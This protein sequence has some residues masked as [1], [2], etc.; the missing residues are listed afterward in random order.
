MPADKS[1][2]ECPFCLVLKAFEDH[3]VGKHIRAAQREVLLAVRT[4]LDARIDALE[5]A[6]ADK[7]KKVKV[8]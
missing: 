8:E 5:E 1:V 6:K 2:P 3:P 4:C 7:P